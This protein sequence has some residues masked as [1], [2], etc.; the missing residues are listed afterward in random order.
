M[1][2]NERK[3]ESEKS[4]PRD[5]PQTKK[6]DMSHTDGLPEVQGDERVYENDQADG[7]GEKN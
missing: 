2:K 1:F 5:L 3:V 6:V 7:S 4:S